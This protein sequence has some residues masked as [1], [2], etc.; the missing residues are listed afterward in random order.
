MKIDKIIKQISEKDYNEILEQFRSNKSE[1]FMFLFT[2]FRD[3]VDEEIIFKNLGISD[4]AYYTLKSRLVDKVQEYLYL[5]IPDERIVLLKNVS[6][7]DR[8]L[9]KFPKE[10]AIALLL[11]MEEDLLVHDMQNELTLVYNALK[12]L[13]VNSPKYYTYT[14][15][16]NK[17]VAFTLSID[18]A[19]TLLLE[20]NK[21]LREYFL[22]HSEKDRSVLKLYKK[23]LSHL[24]S[25]YASHH[26]SVFSKLVDV[27]FAL[28]VKDATAMVDDDTVENNLR[29][30]LQ[31]FQNYPNDKAYLYYTHYVDVLYFEYYFSIKSLKNAQ[32]Y[33]EKIKAGSQDHVFCNR[34]FFTSAVFITILSYYD[35]KDLKAN[36]YTDLKEFALQI[37]EDNFVDNILLSILNAYASMYA[38]KY[39]QGIQQI[40]NLLNQFSFKNYRQIE[41]ELKALLS[42]LYILNDRSELSDGL[43][44]SI[45]KWVSENEGAASDKLHV[46]LRLLRL[47]S[48][49][50]KK[51]VKVELINKIMDEFYLETE[52]ALCFLN[53][54]RLEA[55]HIE[56]ISN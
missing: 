7:I 18:K 5:N 30:V 31:I 36:L 56:V 32:L 43:I 9:F 10:V 42:I 54:I 22:S 39:S 49:N 11:K 50:K 29:D 51:E 15:K 2:S 17:S 26:I 44:R 21:T 34:Y 8:L 4:A 45:S 12:K 20:F 23:E 6:N 35:L 13:Y 27:Q 53:K 28:Y 3:G 16:Y 47:S 19:E 33:L 24:A 25:V 14:Q 37:D 55:I 46:F 52:N 1:K 38:Q 48:N 41:M 40:N